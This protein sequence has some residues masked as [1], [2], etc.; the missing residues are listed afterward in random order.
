MRPTSTITLQIEISKRWN[1]FLKLK[2]TNVHLVNQGACINH[3][4]RFICLG[5]C[6]KSQKYANLSA[7]LGSHCIRITKRIRNPLNKGTTT[8]FIIYIIDFFQHCGWRDYV[9]RQCSTAVQ[10]IWSLDSTGHPSYYWY[11]SR[12]H[13]HRLVQ[14]WLKLGDF[15][16]V[17][18][19][20]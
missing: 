4:F 5:K 2:V 13:P 12:I 18:F 3:S 15:Y 1:A 11:N 8:S 10:T 19:L 7:L 6:I 9:L 20:Y 17:N 14:M 16:T